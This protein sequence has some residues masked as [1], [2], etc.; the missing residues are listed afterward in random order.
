MFKFI[1]NTEGCAN[2]STETYFDECTEEIW[3]PLCQ[4]LSPRIEVVE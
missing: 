1:C 4:S 3:C 2:S